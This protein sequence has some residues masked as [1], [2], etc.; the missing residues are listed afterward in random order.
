M[1]LTITFTLIV[2][3][4]L[5]ELKDESLSIGNG[6]FSPQQAFQLNSGDRERYIL[7]V[8]CKTGSVRVM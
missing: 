4:L 7:A 2:A 8:N 6:F 1:C 5:L 3:E